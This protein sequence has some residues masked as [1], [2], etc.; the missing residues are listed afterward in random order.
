MGGGE[1]DFSGFTLFTK[2]EPV[3]R[4]FANSDPDDPGGA[5]NLAIPVIPTVIFFFR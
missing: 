2:A 3:G 5:V 4:F 1:G